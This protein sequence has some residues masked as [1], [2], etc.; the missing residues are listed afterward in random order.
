MTHKA[1]TMTRLAFACACIAMLGVSVVAPAGAD[2]H[3]RITLCWSHHDR[4]V[5]FSRNGEC[6]RTERRVVLG[7]GD[8]GAQGP[9]GPQGPTGAIGA[10][11]VTGADGATGATGA[12]GATGA[13]GP[14][15]GPIGPTGVT[16]ATGATGAQGPTGPTGATGVGTTGATGGTGAQ[17]VTGATGPTGA[18]ATGATGPTGSAGVNAFHK[19]VV[20]NSAVVT[21]SV[22][23]SCNPGEVVTGGGFDAP[24]AVIHRSAP[25]SAGDGW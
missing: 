10:T 7:K 8:T 19:V 22:T 24:S 18:G 13:T 14:S 21:G 25:T 4:V 17:G 23:A 5:R 11:G 12:Q 3:A 1:K 2:V 16:G 6:A 9:S 20:T 15:G